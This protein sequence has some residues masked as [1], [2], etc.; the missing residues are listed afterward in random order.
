MQAKKGARLTKEE[1]RE[2]ALVKEEERFLPV[3]TEMV[4]QMRKQLWEQ[5]G[6]DRV[7]LDMKGTYLAARHGTTSGKRASQRWT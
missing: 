3:C 5:S 4:M 1:I 2:T 6:S 7:G